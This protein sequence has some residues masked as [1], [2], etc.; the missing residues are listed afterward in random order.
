MKRDEDSTRRPCTTSVHPR[1]RAGRALRLGGVVCALLLV[2]AGRG[3]AQA[4]L[5]APLRGPA[6]TAT[7]SPPTPLKAPPPPPPEAQPGAAGPAPTPPAQ[8]WPPPAMPAPPFPAQPAPTRAQPQR[9]QNFVHFEALGN[10]GLYS[11]N[12]T[13]V[14]LDDFAARVGIS[15]VA[16]GAGIERAGARADALTIPLM[17]HYLGVGSERHRLDLGLGALLLY[18][19]AQARAEASEIARSSFTVVGTASIGYR[20]LPPSGFTFNIGFTPIFGPIFLPWGGV[21]IGHTF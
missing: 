1:A 10:A 2:P 20:Y 4:V 5:P 19:S 14:V 12:Y 16:L 6:P 9:D 8:S 13:R 15:Y 18:A 11:V 7:E 21:G 17:A 3:H